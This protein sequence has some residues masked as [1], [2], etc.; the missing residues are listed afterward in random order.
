MKDIDSIEQQSKVQQHRNRDGVE[1]GYAMIVTS[2]FSMDIVTIVLGSIVTCG[3][4]CASEYQLSKKSKRLATITVVTAVAKIITWGVFF[5]LFF[6]SFYQLLGVSNNIG[7]INDDFNTGNY[8]S[9]FNNDITDFND[10]IT[11]I[12]ITTLSAGGN[13]ILNLICILS[14]MNILFACLYTFQRG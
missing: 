13:T 11:H 8:G 10:E 7:E 3:C 14:I 2:F 6:N 12:A 5:V 4:C 9:D 1:I